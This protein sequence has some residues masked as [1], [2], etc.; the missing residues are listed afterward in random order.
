MKTQLVICLASA[1]M[2]FS[3][4]EKREKSLEES[5]EAQ[6]EMQGELHQGDTTLVKRDGTLLDGALDTIDSIGL[7]PTVLE[8]IAQD[9]NL[10]STEILS[11]R[12]YEEDNKTFY[13]VK[14]QLDEKRSTT[15]VFD[16]KG[17]QKPKL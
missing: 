14:F 8:T 5:I 12:A 3:S 9:P 10:A 6:N 13:E 11:T 1:V 16:E 15:L 4:C 17:K 7:P 2:L